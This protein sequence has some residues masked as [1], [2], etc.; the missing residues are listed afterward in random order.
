MVV[1]NAKSDL[2]EI[3]MGVSHESVL[4]PLLYLLYVLRVNLAGINV[5][6][7]KFADDIALSYRNKC[8]SL[9]EKNINTDLARHNQWLCCNKLIINLNKSVY[10]L[11]ITKKI[12]N[13]TVPAVKLKKVE[14]CK[15]LRFIR[16]Q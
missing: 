6:Y 13:K 5:Q 3:T 7:F 8:I 1:N 12:N 10:K 11:I 4:R 2:A 14:T 16:A 9:Q 15:V